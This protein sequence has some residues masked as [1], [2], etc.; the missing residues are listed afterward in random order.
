MATSDVTFFSDGLRV[1]GQ[2]LTPDDWKPGDPPRPGILV[3]PGYSGNAKVDCAHL[4]RRLC[5]EGW[6]VLS[7]YYRGFGDSEGTRGRHRPLEQAQNAYDALSYLQAVPGVDP[8]RLGLYGTSF[9]GANGVW[10]TAHDERVKCLV[11]SVAVTNGERWMR[12]IRRPCEWWAFRDRVMEDA[13]RRVRTG[14]PGMV[15]KGDIMI[16]DPDTAR[17]RK[18]HEEEGHAFH[19]QDLDLESAEALF[20]HRPEWVVDRISPR[21]VLMIY[22]ERDCL[23]PPEEQLS[24]YAKCGEPK[25]LVMLP[26]G[27]HYDS[28][29]FG[30]A[31]MSKIVYRETIAWFNRYL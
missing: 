9:G 25:K 11:T 31:E 15:P 3:L 22:G 13:R 18:I 16:R 26:S 14:T 27:A 1:A 29:E 28:Y 17:Q 2:L 4:M 30:N 20:R 6:F 5:S 8:E 23:V 7:F 12:L 21:P 19:D 24:C 10:V